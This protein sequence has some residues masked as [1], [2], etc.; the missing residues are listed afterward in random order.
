MLNMYN[1]YVMG[2]ILGEE[3]IKD[4][5]LDNFEDMNMEKVAIKVEKI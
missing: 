2:E 1:E 5:T 4:T 3:L